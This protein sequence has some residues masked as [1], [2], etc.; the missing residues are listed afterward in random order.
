MKVLLLDNYDSFTYNLYQLV[1]EILEDQ[2]QI[3]QLDVFRNDK[4]TLEEISNRNYDRILI[5][6]GPGHPKDPSYFG[7][8]ESVLS[9]LGRLVPILGICLGMQG[10]AT[11]FGGQV[12]R[13]Q[14]PMHGKTSLIKHDEKGVFK[15]ISQEIEIMRYHSLVVDRS[16][17]PSFFHITA[18]TLDKEIMGLRHKEWPMEGVQFHPE[19]FASEE[20]KVMLQNFLFSE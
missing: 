10:M 19:S 15:N 3:F 14:D 11:A 18:E 4:I 17:I 6:P 20:G 13:A 9:N 7:V 8:S 2:I 16:T 1:G 5:S 12:I